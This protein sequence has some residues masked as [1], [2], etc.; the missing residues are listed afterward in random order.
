MLYKLAGG[1]SGPPF[2]YFQAI[3]VKGNVKVNANSGDCSDT[4]AAYGIAMADRTSSTYFMLGSGTLL[5]QMY[6]EKAGSICRSMQ[7]PCVFG[8]SYHAQISYG[9]PSN[10]SMTTTEGYAT[11]HMGPYALIEY[12][13]SLAVAKYAP[14]AWLVKYNCSG[15]LNIEGTPFL[16]G[17]KMIWVPGNANLI[18]GNGTWCMVVFGEQELSYAMDDVTI[19]FANS[20]KDT[21]PRPGYDNATMGIAGD[22]NF[23]GK[24]NIVDVQIIYDIATGA[25]P[26]NS[27]DNR[28]VDRWVMADV[29]NDN[30]VDAA[31]AYAACVAIIRG[32][33]I[34]K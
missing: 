28:L 29:N 26:A 11:W 24:L 4:S 27:G 5:A 30:Y 1:P 2:L 19:R 17:K 31:D 25:L 14:G 20:S 7:Y 33:P 9:Y 32:W 21:A 6:N 10:P 12:S 23:N 8:D 16:N 3:N 15:G 34:E 13:N 18:S 22:L